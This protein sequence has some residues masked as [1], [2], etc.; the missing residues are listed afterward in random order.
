MA[1][2]DLSSNNLVDPVTTNLNKLAHNL[3]NAVVTA[4]AGFIAIRIVSW[5]AG[6]LIGFVNMPK[7]LKGIIISLLDT[8]LM[9]ILVIV[10]LEALGL[11]NV[12]FIVTAAVA[13][14]GIAMGN[15]SVTL[16]SDILAGVY[17]AQDRNFSI[18]DIVQAGENQIE[19]EIVSM[20]MRRTR[21][22]DKSGAV[23]SIPNSVIERKEYVLITKRRDRTDLAK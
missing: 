17:L 15:G 21:I 14:L 12:A 6:W 11:N 3:P 19:G 4:L 1:L 2:V 16:V 13:G 20:D 9:V 22:R 8:L 7:G 5:L 10:T 23:H 18:G